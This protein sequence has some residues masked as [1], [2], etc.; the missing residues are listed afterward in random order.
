MEPAV[1]DPRE[2]EPPFRPLIDSAPV[3]LLLADREGRCVYVNQQWCAL[4]GIP[5]Q[6]ALGSGWLRV[7]HPEDRPAMDRRWE[8]CARGRQQET[9]VFRWV[10]PSGSVLR[11][12]GSVA[13]VNGPVGEVLGIVAAFVGLP[14]AAQS[15]PD[16][17]RRAREI[18]SRRKLL[19][20]LTRIE[21]AGLDAA[22]RRILEAGLRALSVERI[23]VWLYSTDRSELVCVEQVARRPAACERGNRFRLTDCPK[24]VSA[25]R[26]SR[27]LAVREA[28]LDPRTSEFCESYL[29]PR[30]V[31]S[32][33]DVP[34]CRQGRVVGILSHEETG[35]DLRDWSPD[36]RDLA[37]SLADSVA[38]A[39]DADERRRDL[40]T[41]A[42][43]EKQLRCLVQDSRDAIFNLRPDG[44]LES[45]NPAFEH[46]TGWSRAEW[47]GRSFTPLVH[48]DDV[49]LALRRLRLAMGGVTTPMFEIRLRARE[50][51]WVVAEFVAIPQMEGGQVHGVWGIAHDITERRLAEDEIRRRNAFLERRV[52]ERTADL[53]ALNRELEVLGETLVRELQA[54]V[55]EIVAAA[56]T[57]TEESPTSV[58][59]PHPCIL[60]EIGTRASR[61]SA[62][63]DDLLRLSQVVR[64]PLLVAE[65]DMTVL[66]EEAAADV[67][68]AADGRRVN[69]RVHP[70]PRAR[71]D[72]GLLREVFRHL[73]D[74]AVKFTRAQP[75]P[76]IDVRGD[77]RR[78]EL[79]FRVTDNG[80]GF[81]MSCTGSLFGV[82]RRLH[83]DQGFEGA[84]IGL[85]LVQRIVRRHGGTAWAEG[86]VDG[87]ATFWFSLP[88][89]GMP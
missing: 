48:P 1:R 80:V 68:P 70:L 36:D 19:L 89:R 78:D 11:V 30:G 6:D 3:G 65:V 45:V 31:I 16:T 43:S 76:V 27:V 33:M 40:E 7:L 4:A 47:L 73:L 87:G 56:V 82:F 85:A 86:K 50:G 38:T 61:A 54:P 10:L 71:G 49:D 46:T 28:R 63:I 88:S 5:P 62:R 75:N 44:T 79:H 29:V 83:A 55:R 81:D 66:A 13:L 37:L 32:R 60:Q 34:V 53:E 15:E 74:N 69:L 67:L 52:T 18:A 26:E 77:L 59:E 84:G 41:L 39:L 21:P 57:T 72:A 24:Y 8:A 17:G 22:L 51:G 35:P 25:L 58:V 2:C 42:Q 9:F 64:Q 23:A 20:E 14:A 12:S